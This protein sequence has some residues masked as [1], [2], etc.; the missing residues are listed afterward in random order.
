VLRRV[1]E[2]ACESEG[3]VQKALTV[4]SRAD[5]Y[6]LDTDTHHH[7]GRWLAQQLARFYGSTKPAHW[8]GLH[9]SII[10]AKVKIR[11]PGGLIYKNTEEDWI[12]LSEKA[13]KAARW[14]G[15]IPFDRIIDKRNNAPII[16][17]VAKIEPQATVLA[18]LDVELPDDIAPMPSAD[19]FVAR[20][21]FSFACF[22]EKA[23]LE[24]VCLPWAEQYQV[25]LYLGTGETSDTLIYQI[26]RDAVADE[27][28]LVVFT[29]TDCDP[30]GWQMVISIARKLQAIQDLQFSALRWEIVHVGLTPDQVREFELAVEPIK[31]GDK[32]REAWKRAFDVDQ[33]E[34]DALTTPEMTERGILRQLLDDAIEPYIDPDLADEVERAE[35]EWHEEAQAAVD[36]QLD[37]HDDEGDPIT[38][39][40]IVPVEGEGFRQRPK[41]TDKAKEALDLLGEAVLDYGEKP[42]ASTRIPPGQ[43]YVVRVE[44]FRKHFYAG[45]INGDQKP[46]T[47]LKAFNRATQQLKKLGYIGVW[48]DLIWL[49]GH[50]GQGRT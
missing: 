27:R 36:A 2:A 30:S 8:R 35:S 40:V 4:L 1:L 39:C 47:K 23:S 24:E 18:G 12:W 41:L 33:T 29:V 45:T 38:S 37:A 28:P 3:V 7:N 16:H 17:R 31:V 10:M 19:G 42:P 15:Y 25:D 43:N 50:A 20:Q 32:R 22:G 9:Y 5:P 14:L 26:A 6:R 44:H 11:K 34:I 48:N 46:D 21:A 49:T 13:G